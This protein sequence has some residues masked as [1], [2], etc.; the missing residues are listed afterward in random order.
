MRSRINLA[1][2]LYINTK[3]LNVVLLLAGVVLSILLFINFQHVLQT[4]KE[5][6][7]LLKAYNKNPS[8]DR[9]VPSQEYQALLSRIKVA[10][11][12]IEQ[13]TFNWLGLLD[14]LETVVPDGVFLNGVDPSLRTNELK[15]SGVARNF[16]NLRRLMENLEDSS[17][18]TNVYLL[19]QNE[20]K[21]AGDKTGIT[22]NISCQV[23]FK[24][25]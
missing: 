2:R 10:N 8:P 13:K 11:G 9:E 22:F 14:K 18:F 23:D 19:G 12:I 3:Q 7:R 1:T 20:T 25:L 17:T 4:Q 6:G 24:K 16:K 21:G 15:I 5:T